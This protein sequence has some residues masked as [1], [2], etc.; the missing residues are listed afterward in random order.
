LRSA[1]TSERL[2]YFF[3]SDAEDDL[4][5]LD[6]D[7]SLFMRAAKSMVKACAVKRLDGEMDILCPGG[8]VSLVVFVFV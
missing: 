6:L 4:E 2:R 8:N 7:S 1:S 3:S 5:D